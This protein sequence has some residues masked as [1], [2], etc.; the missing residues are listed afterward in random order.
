[1]SLHFRCPVRWGD[2]DAQGH[3]NNG[4]FLDYLQEA[5]VHF[6]LTG[7]PALQAMLGSGV[8]VV[9]HQVEYRKP[10]V[11]GDGALD[12]ELWVDAVGASRFAIGYDLRAGGAVVA[13]ARTAAV[14]YDLAG[15]GLRRLSPEERAVLVEQVQ[16]AP[17]LRAVVKAPVG[18]RAHRYSLA[19]R[20]S[21]LDSYGHVNNVKYFDYVQEA[22]VAMVGDTLGWRPEDVWM[23]VRQDLEYV[24]P[25]DFRLEPYEVRT[26]VAAMGGRSFTIAAEI[27]DP[28]SAT[29]F[30]TARTVVVGP[31]PLSEDVRAAFS[32]WGTDTLH[33]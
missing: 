25:I 3:V 23:V 29:V 6:L 12:V 10:L 2:M 33:P 14:P 21:D 18:E 19:V 7:P 30:A 17:P 13:H 1:M 22:R 4:A 32:R 28:V 15:R 27:S 5:R 24:R 16:P 31:A 9:G 8:L 20:W 26:A 11:V